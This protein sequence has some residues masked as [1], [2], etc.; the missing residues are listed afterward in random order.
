MNAHSSTVA[1]D[2][3][4]FSVI[5]SARSDFLPFSRRVRNI[6]DCCCKQWKSRHSH[7]LRLG[8]LHTPQ[9][10]CLSALLILKS[11]P[12]CIPAVVVISC[13][14]VTMPRKLI[15][16]AAIAGAAYA[17]SRSS[18]QAQPEQQLHHPSASTI[19]SPVTQALP[20][21]Q[22]PGGN[23]TFDSSVLPAGHPSLPADH[24]ALQALSQSPRPTPASHNPLARPGGCPMAQHR[25]STSSSSPSPSVSEPTSEP[26]DSAP[27]LASLAYA[28]EPVSLESGLHPLGELTP[29]GAIPAAGR[30]N[31]PDGQNWVNPS[32]N[33][34]YRALK[35]KQKAIDPTDALAVSTVHN[36]VTDNTWQCILEYEQHHSRACP[37]GPT[38]ARFYGMDGVY[39]GKAKF[40]NGVL[41]GP[42]PFDRHDWIVDRC[43]KEVRYIID[44][45]SVEVPTGSSGQSEAGSSGGGE[46]GSEEV[47]VYYSVDARP[48]PTLE[49]LWERSKMAWRKWQAGEQ[50]W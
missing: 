16:L 41:G 20:M 5:N 27:H 1:I 12:I 24:P 9:L 19:S 37:Q 18:A 46:G 44:Y 35:R 25:S 28:S 40:V 23:T 29:D 21:A 22:R 42:L 30:G 34:L 39:S 8:A 31:S 26:P 14:C 36:A 13:H 6:A 2:Q 3:V 38:L 7:C 43:G 48:A 11:A 15:G 50:W 49:G 17:M 4:E 10:D 32:A 47:E 45:Y 33:S